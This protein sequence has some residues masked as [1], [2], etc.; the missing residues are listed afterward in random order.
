[1]I[2]WCTYVIFIFLVSDIT[3]RSSKNLTSWMDFRGNSRNSLDTC[4]RGGGQMKKCPIVFRIIGR[5]KKKKNMDKL[6]FLC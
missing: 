6:E 1:M 3:V 4:G 2:Y 5:N